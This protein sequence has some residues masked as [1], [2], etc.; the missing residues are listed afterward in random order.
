[1][2]ILLADDAI[3]V[4]RLQ[5]S[6]NHRPT[7]NGRVQLTAS[8]LGFS[9][10]ITTPCALTGRLGIRAI[11]TRTG[12]LSVYPLTNAITLATARCSARVRANP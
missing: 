11:W 10:R 9:Q 1:M 4:D 12:N 7:G 6:A 8:G 5:S 2:V 3:P